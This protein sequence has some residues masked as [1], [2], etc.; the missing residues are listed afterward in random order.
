[1]KKTFTK[2][3]LILL[4]II[5]VMILLLVAILFMKISSFFSKKTE[6][7]QNEYAQ[8][9]KWNFDCVEHSY[10]DYIGDFFQEYAV[11]KG[12]TL[13]SISKNELGDSSRVNEIIN[14][15]SKKYPN[16]S[17]RD[18]FIEIGWKL[19]LPPKEITTS[20]NLFVSYGKLVDK[21]DNK[22]IWTLSNK[23]GNSYGYYYPSQFT[24]IE[25]DIKVGDC[26]DLI[27]ERPGQIIYEIHKQK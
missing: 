1:M 14:L 19:L 13:L 25:E 9:E 8:Y 11:K 26:I 12:D 21:N 20:G 7:S 2:R 6:S 4:T 16:I 5:V 18:P 3:V 17:F 23:G 27:T 10:A 15:N 22:K 24:I